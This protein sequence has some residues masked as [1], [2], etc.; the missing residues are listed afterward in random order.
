M[1][2]RST[3]VSCIRVN[4][5]RQREDLWNDTS[6][7]L[8]ELS[9]SRENKKTAKNSLPWI[10]PIGG[11]GDML[12]LSGVLKLV[13]EKDPSRRFNL[14]RRTNYLD[15]LGRHPAIA[16]VGFPPKNAKVIGVDYWYMEELGPGNH[17]AFQV[18]ARSFGLETPVEE[19]LYLHDEFVEDP[20]LHNFLPWKKVNILIA[21]ASDSPRKT[22]YP[23]IWHHLV[24]YLLSDGAFVMQAGRFNEQHIRNAYSVRGLTTPRQLV[25]LIRKCD[26]VITVDNFIMHAAHLAGIPAVVIWGPT[27]HEVYGYPEQVHLQMPP[28][29]GLRNGESCIVSEKNRGGGLYNT[30]CPLG[31]RHCMDQI[32]PEAI[33]EASRKALLRG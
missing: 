6:S 13:I 2:I 3:G 21:S 25:A 11:Y 29:C 12:M 10:N 5:V 32:K 33:Y 27:Q 9:L 26:L 17:R 8:L 15:I 28:M 24:D 19:R 14:I 16:S 22:V 31:E 7:L 30:P 20:L 18:L 4:G 1:P 23:T